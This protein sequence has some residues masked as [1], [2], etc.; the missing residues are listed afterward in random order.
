MTE[1]RTADPARDRIAAW[2][3]DGQRPERPHKEG[4]L[5][6]VVGAIALVAGLIAAL[7]TLL[8]PPAAP[9]PTRLAVVT[10]SHR[11]SAGGECS[12]D[13]RMPTGEIS[14]L[15]PFV[16]TPPGEFVITS[17]TPEGLLQAKRIHRAA[18]IIDPAFS[19]A[20]WFGIALA[21]AG[22]G[23]AVYSAL[24]RRRGLGRGRRATLA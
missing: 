2:L 9:D 20:I 17:E 11:L 8:N 15:R 21:A 19:A 5:L 23:A 6:I 10:A 14:T 4:R 22:A 7:V 3:A 24:R 1:E 13:I 18:R 12:L 16:C